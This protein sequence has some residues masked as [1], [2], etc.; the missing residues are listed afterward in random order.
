M[1]TIISGGRDYRFSY[2]DISYLDDLMGWLPITEV[3]SGTARGADKA[4]EAWA[5]SRGLPVK[6]FPADW[7]RHGRKA[8]PLRNLDM[9]DYA[10]ALVAFPGGDGT[11]DMV[12]T[13]RHRRLDIFDCRF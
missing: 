5:R 9:A 3:V 13:A 8:G 2:S 10:D 12:K 4:G 1:R 6:Q 11:K 7:E